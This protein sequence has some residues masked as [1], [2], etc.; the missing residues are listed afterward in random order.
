M[1]RSRVCYRACVSATHVVSSLVVLALPGEARAEIMD[2]AL[3]S[4]LP[5]PPLS[6]AWKAEIDRRGREI[7]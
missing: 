2:A 5:A 6:D 4:L 7:D 1:E 3:E